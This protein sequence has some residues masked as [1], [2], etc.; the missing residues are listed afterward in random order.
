[1]LIIL[2]HL[3]VSVHTGHLWNESDP[4]IFAKQARVMLYVEDTKMKGPWWVAIRAR[5]RYL[6]DPSL[7]LCSDD[8]RLEN[9]VRVTIE[10]EAYQMQILD[11]ILVPYNMVDI[12]QLQWDDCEARMFL[13]LEH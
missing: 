7:F 2:D 6:L 5:H 3:L 8:E 9:E 13:S 4:Y 10:N 12:G 1:M 11:N